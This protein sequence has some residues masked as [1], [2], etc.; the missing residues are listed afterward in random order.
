MR[1][2]VVSDPHAMRVLRVPPQPKFGVF[3]INYV[4]TFIWIL[5]AFALFCI[6]ATRLHCTLAWRVRGVRRVVVADPDPHRG[7]QT[8]WM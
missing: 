2:V 8:R 1:V 5:V 4:K 3:S 7:P 6:V